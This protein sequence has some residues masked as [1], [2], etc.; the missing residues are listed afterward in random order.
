MRYADVTNEAEN[1]DEEQETHQ[2]HTLLPRPLEKNSV[3][4][5]SAAQLNQVAHVELLNATMP[6]PALAAMEALKPVRRDESDKG[7]RQEEGDSVCESQLEGGGGTRPAPL[8]DRERNASLRESLHNVPRLRA[9][10]ALLHPIRHRP[11][12]VRREPLG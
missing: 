12:D 6:T 2:R 11:Q 1:G 8:V 10:D 3:V 5:E 4:Y 9:R 7:L